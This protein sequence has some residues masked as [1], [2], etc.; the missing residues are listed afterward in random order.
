M[1]TDIK[2]RTTK[3][4]DEAQKPFD[5]RGLYLLITSTGSRYWRLKYRFGSKE[6]YSP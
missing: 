5:G 6:N 4:Q 1:L 2:A 3:P